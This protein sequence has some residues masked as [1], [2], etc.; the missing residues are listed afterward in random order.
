ML[1]WS[2]LSIGQLS[3]KYQ[4]IIIYYVKFAKTNYKNSITR[5]EYL[6]TAQE[7]SSWNREILLYGIY[8]Y[9]YIYHYNFLLRIIKI[10]IT[11]EIV[12]KSLVVIIFNFIIFW[13][14]FIKL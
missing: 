1:R 13:F 7:G 8:T 9:I 3:M 10:V 11:V 5:D 6:N 4:L 14:Y 12:L 2:N